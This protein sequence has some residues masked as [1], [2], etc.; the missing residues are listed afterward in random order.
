MSRDA[1]RRPPH[2]IRLGIIGLGLASALTLPELARHPRIKL[3]AAADLRKHALARFASDH[4]GATFDSAEALCSSGHVD[5]VY[6]CTPNMLHRSH[7]VTAAAAGKHVLVEKPMGMT[8]RDCTEMVAAARRHDVQLVYGHTH[9]QDPAVQAMAAIVSQG[10]L[11]PLLTVNA[12]NFNDLM[13]RPRDAWE[14]DS[15]R[16][17]GVVYIQAPHQLD[18]VREVGGPISSIHAQTTRASERATEDGYT[19]YVQFRGG[20]SGALVYSG[21][22]FFDSAELIGW[23]GEDGR[24]RDP[25]THSRAHAGLRRREASGSE[26]SARE[27]RR[28]GATEPEQPRSGRRHQPNFGLVVASFAAGDV[29]Q[30][31]D[32]RWIYDSKGRREISLRG[33]PSGRRAMLDELVDAVLGTRPPVHDGEWGRATVEACQAILRSAS[34]GR[35]VSLTG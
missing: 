27:A 33:R 11:G 5:A 19:A 20:A 17:G 14:L 1:R 3:T 25:E 21:R 13:V 9:A 34:S 4:G 28:Y 35:S 16:G 12:W 22:G 26:A 24:R 10:S 18:I 7:V 8:A 31:P 30:S 32:G 23:I 6:V 15:R 2:R 29:R